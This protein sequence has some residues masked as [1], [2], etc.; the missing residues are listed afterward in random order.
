MRRTLEQVRDDLTDLFLGAIIPIS[1]GVAVAGGLVG[2]WLRL[3]ELMG[4]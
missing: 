3:L 4:P 2:G 1:I